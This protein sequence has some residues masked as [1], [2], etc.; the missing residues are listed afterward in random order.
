M[1]ALHQATALSVRKRQNHISR[2]ADIVDGGSVEA[3]PDEKIEQQDPATAVVTRT[4]RD[5]SFGT[6]VRRAY[7]YACAACG[8][9]FDILD[10][11]HIIPVTVVRNF[12]TRNGLCLCPNHHR[13]YDNGLI[14]FHGDF[15]IDV[16]RELVAR[17]ERQHRNKGRELLLDCLFRNLHVPSNPL[18]QP[19]PNLLEQRLERIRT[20]ELEHYEKT[21]R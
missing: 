2:V 18:E 10:A 16:D 21:H 5:N 3:P 20:L 9:Q 1:T 4:I 19:A 11:A 8:L 6:R 17:Y 13:A 7:G 15:S 12:S 14:L